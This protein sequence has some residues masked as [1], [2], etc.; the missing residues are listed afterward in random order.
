MAWVFIAGFRSSP[1]TMLEVA[2]KFG[3]NLLCRLN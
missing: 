1:P 3:S 2:E